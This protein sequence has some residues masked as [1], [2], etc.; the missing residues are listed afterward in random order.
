VLSK[1]NI[2]KSPASYT[3]NWGMGF[4]SPDH[5]RLTECPWFDGDPN[6][7]IPRFFKGPEAKNSCNPIPS[8]QRFGLIWGPTTGTIPI[9]S[10]DVRVAQFEA[11]SDRI[12]VGPILLTFPCCAGAVPIV[13]STEQSIWIYSP[14]SVGGADAFRLSAVTGAVLQRAQIPAIRQPAVVANAEGL[15]FGLA[16]P[17]NRA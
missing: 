6:Q 13:A 7:P 15:W 17:P 11:G 12:E 5:W 2:T 8:R 9:E 14:Y 1:F 4:S 10:G 3:P 16:H